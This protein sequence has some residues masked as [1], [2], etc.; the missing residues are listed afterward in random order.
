MKQSAERGGRAW[1]WVGIVLLCLS[2]LLWLIIILVIASDGDGAGIVAGLMFTAIPIGIG[3][4]G[5]WRGKRQ[6]LTQQISRR[7]IRTGQEL[8]AGTQG[9]RPATE[10]VSNEPTSDTQ[11]LAAYIKSAKPAT[12][13]MSDGQDFEAQEGNV[14]VESTTM[15]TL[16]VSTW[17]R[18]RCIWDIF[19]LSFPLWCP[20][21]VAIIRHDGLVEVYYNPP[22]RNTETTDRFIRRMIWFSSRTMDKLLNHYGIER[23]NTWAMGKVRSEEGNRKRIWRIV[24]LTLDKKSPQYIPGAD[25]LSRLA[26]TNPQHYLRLCSAQWVE[27]SEFPGWPARGVEFRFD[28]PF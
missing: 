8:S 19:V 4:Y 14:A 7:P 21:N 24:R 3:I 15:L 18:I 11:G 20:G 13:G 28:I 2:A 27:E 12:E 5:I 16:T 25:S 22:A 17:E 26:A 1:F 6:T 10:R 9:G 23:V